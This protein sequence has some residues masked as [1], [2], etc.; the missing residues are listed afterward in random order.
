M[1]NNF[2]YITYKSRVVEV[3]EE[4]LRDCLVQGTS[5]KGTITNSYK[6]LVEIFGKPKDISNFSVLGTIKCDVEWII[7]TTQGIA[8]IYNY[9]DGK[10]YLGK[11]GKK[12]EDIKEWHIG[13]RN[14]EVVDEILRAVY[15]IIKIR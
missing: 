9:K 12:V 7:F 15:T 6:K 3:D 1:K 11:E 13:G 8:T 4:Q 14:K 10:N 5:L 2:K